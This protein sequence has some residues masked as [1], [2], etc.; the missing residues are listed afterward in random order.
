MSSPN[1]INPA[2]ATLKAVSRL[3]SLMLLIWIEVR[4]TK[5]SLVI[6]RRVA[7][8]EALEERVIVLLEVK[9]L[10]LALQMVLN[11][12]HGLRAMIARPISKKL[13]CRVLLFRA[14]PWKMA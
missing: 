5:T 11:S 10:S 12:T 4:A 9:S 8:V 2:Q 6:G 13:L 3:R 14:S 7:F 1:L